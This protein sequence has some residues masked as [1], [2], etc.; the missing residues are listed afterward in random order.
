[1]AAGQ[2]IQALFAC[3]CGAGQTLRPGFG[4]PGHGSEKSITSEEYLQGPTGETPLTLDKW[5]GDSAGA[6]GL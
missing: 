3:K 4:L 2:E 5:A 6:W 1:V